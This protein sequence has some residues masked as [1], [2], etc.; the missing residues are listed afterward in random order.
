MTLRKE[1]SSA[2]A[3]A[4]SLVTRSCPHQIWRTVGVPDRLRP[5]PMRATTH[6][7]AI[8]EVSHHH[9]MVRE[10][11]VHSKS[12]SRRDWS[13]KCTRWY[14]NTATGRQRSVAGCRR[15]RAQRSCSGTSCVSSGRRRRCEAALCA[16]AARRCGS[17]V[18]GNSA[19]RCVSGRNRHIAVARRASSAGRPRR[20]V[21]N[22]AHRCRAR[23]VGVPHPLVDGGLQE[24]ACDAP[25][26]AASS[27]AWVVPPRTRR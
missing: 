27:A 7:D 13:R 9:R 15:R 18:A 16:T 23:R 12:A 20:V 10:Q 4:I 21:A 6:P 25:I 5:L 8:R 14:F 11:S 19:G 22:A 2:T 17:S 24:G 1:L 26:H 3:V